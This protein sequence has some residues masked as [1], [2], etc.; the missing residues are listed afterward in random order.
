M[1]MHMH[2]HLYTHAH[3]H[4]H[5]HM[6]MHMH[7]HKLMHTPMHMHMHMH[8]HKLT[9]NPALASSQMPPRPRGDPD[10]SAFTEGEGPADEDDEVADNGQDLEVGHGAPCPICVLHFVTPLPELSDWRPAVETGQLGVL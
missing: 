1:H 9:H 3:M 5:L 7:T 8:T 6:H 2:M 4:M 10:V